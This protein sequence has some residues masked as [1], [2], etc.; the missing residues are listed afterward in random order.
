[1]TTRYHVLDWN[2]TVRV[3]RPYALG[4][5]EPRKTEVRVEAQFDNEYDARDF[6]AKVR[7]LLEQP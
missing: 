6:E 2:L 4:V 3:D 7:A 5:S 1:M